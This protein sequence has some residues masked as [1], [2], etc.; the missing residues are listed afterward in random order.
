[1]SISGSGYSRGTQMIM[2]TDVEELDAYY[3]R[4]KPFFFSQFLLESIKTLYLILQQI[5]IVNQTW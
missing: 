3:N 5:L 1:M 2:F 4:N